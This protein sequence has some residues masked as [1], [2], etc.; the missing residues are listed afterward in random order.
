MV[1]STSRGDRARRPV[2][3]AV[4]GDSAS[5]KTTLTRGLVAALGGDGVSALCV[6]AYH[7]YDRQER[8]D[9]PFTPL[10]P[11]CNYLGI[12]EQHLQLVAMGEPILMPVYDHGGGTL[13]R[14]VMFEPDDHVIVEGLF[15]LHS[16]LSRACFDLSV[17]LDPPEEVR[18]TWKIQRDTRDRG[19]QP[20]EVVEDLRRREPDSAA[21]IRPQRRWAD[22]VVTMAPDGGGARGHGDGL[23]A[24]ILL[25]PTAPHPDFSDIFTEDTREAVHLKLARDHDGRP[26][27]ALH[28]RADASRQITR[29]VATAIWTTLGI[30]GEVPDALGVVGA[31]VRSEPLAVV[32]LILLYHLLLAHGAKGDDPEAMPGRVGAM[33]SV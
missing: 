17:Y 8:K 21:F 29:L 31:G 2:L 6:D 5:G 18:R 23:S 11:A 33:R 4:A 28:V 10:D 20:E 14:P 1:T 24:T 3:L 22:I 25:R 9:L 26:V 16:R 27:D 13:E 7:R 32:Q 15:P 12:M 30:D 19:Y